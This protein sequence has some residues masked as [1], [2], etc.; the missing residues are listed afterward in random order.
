VDPTAASILSVKDGAV[1]TLER[2]SGLSDPDRFDFTL[3]TPVATL[4]GVGSTSFVGSPALFFDRLESSWRAWEGELRWGT[5]E[6]EF[7]LT[8]SCDRLGHIQ[9]LVE[10]RS[11]PQ[12]SNWEFKY[13]LHLD[14][15]SLQNISR[16][17]RRA[18]PI[19]AKASAN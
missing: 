1:L 17:F 2:K 6:G 15:G 3:T 10:L 12:P 9:I 4:S 8:A 13:R 11:R 7:E 19:N 16:E 14:A 18:F 5:L